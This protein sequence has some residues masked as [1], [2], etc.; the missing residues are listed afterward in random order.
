MTKRSLDPSHKEDLSGFLVEVRA[1]RPHFH[2]DLSKL[3]FD[4]QLR[5][6]QGD[7]L[8]VH[9]ALV[10]CEQG[11]LPLPIWLSAAPMSHFVDSL[12][13]GAPGSKGRGKSPMGEARK[14]LRSEVHFRTVQAVRRLARCV[15]AERFVA[16]FAG[17]RSLHHVF[18]KLIWDKIT[19]PRHE[20]QISDFTTSLEGAYLA[21]SKLLRGTFAQAEAR[22][23]RR[24][25]K[26]VERQR[27]ARDTHLSEKI[28][29]YST[30]LPETLQAFG[31]QIELSEVEMYAW[32]NGFTVVEMEPDPDAVPRSGVAGADRHR[33]VRC[34]PA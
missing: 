29:W 14:R 24:S 6:E 18:P 11:C 34:G 2:G 19:D 3:V 1:I 23:I 15:E 21:A 26:S 9:D 12:T 20:L 10:A 16:S 32:E 17:E 28:E 7:V 33:D 4:C 30:C 8:A 22:T 27:T 5:Y 25:F 13:G 31:L